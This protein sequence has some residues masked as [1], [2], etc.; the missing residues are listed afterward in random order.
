VLY[1][2]RV[3]PDRQQE[4]LDALLGSLRS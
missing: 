2:D 3:G 1:P 4:M